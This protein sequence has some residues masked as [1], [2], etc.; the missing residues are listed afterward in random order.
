MIA[1]MNSLQDNTNQDDSVFS[2][3]MFNYCPQNLREEYY[4]T[5]DSIN[6]SFLK[7]EKNRTLYANYFKENPDPEV[8]V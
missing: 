6:F 2:C 4:Y 3:V 1:L 7:D 8:I 5:F